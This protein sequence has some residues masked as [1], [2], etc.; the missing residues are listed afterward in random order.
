M[1]LSTPCRVRAETST[2][3]VSPPQ[4]SGT[5]PL[6]WSCWRTFSGFAFGWSI[7]FTATRMG[8]FAS[9]A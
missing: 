9:R 8:T 7:L 1:S 4:S 3:I 5:S 2:K 6:S